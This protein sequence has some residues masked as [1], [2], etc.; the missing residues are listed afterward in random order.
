MGEVSGPAEVAVGGS[1]ETT[2]FNALRDGVLSRYTVLPWED[3]TEYQALLTAVVAEHAPS[4]VTEEHLVEEQ[5]ASS[6]GNAG[7]AWRRQQFTGRTSDRKRPTIL[8][9]HLTRWPVRH[10]SLSLARPK[11]S[12]S[13]RGQQ[14]AERRT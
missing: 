14:L 6:G 13:W 12:W 4:G 9:L 11:A 7:C 8:T 1:Y 3:K 2:R 10:S 5:P